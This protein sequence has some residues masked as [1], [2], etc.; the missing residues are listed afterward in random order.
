L[1][2][3]DCQPTNELRR[4]DSRATQLD[5]TTLTLRA[6]FGGA[7]H[8]GGGGKASA[9]G[10]RHGAFGGTSVEREKVGAQLGA[11][12]GG[13][14][15]GDGVGGGSSANKGVS[16]HAVG[17]NGASN[18]ASHGGYNGTGH[19]VGTSHGVSGTSGQAADDARDVTLSVWDLGGQIAYAAAQ[20]PYIVPGSLYLLAVAAPRA[21]VSCDGRS[22]LM[23]PDGH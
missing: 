12:G 1:I 11:K 23:A 6:A 9:E 20:Q 19:G 22:L 18:G 21:S 2:V 13:G 8:G 17:S 3:L 14:R 10:A 5:I 4:V 15:S 7:R 16:S